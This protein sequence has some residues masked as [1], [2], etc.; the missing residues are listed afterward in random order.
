MTKKTII[1]SLVF[2]V[3]GYIDNLYAGWP[4][5]IAPEITGIITDKTTG[6][7]IENALLI[8]EWSDQYY[9]GTDTPGTAVFSEKK[10]FSDKD[11]KYEIPSKT[12]FN[13][14]STF[15]MITAHVIHPLYERSGLQVVTRLLDIFQKVNGI[16]AIDY[17]RKYGYWIIN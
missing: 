16:P 11:G 5:N 17:I 1:I 6:E 10:I 7:P 4:I 3:I 14:I 9:F 2:F 12:S 15:D 13:L 8:V